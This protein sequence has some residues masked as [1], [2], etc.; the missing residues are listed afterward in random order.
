MKASNRDMSDRY[1]LEKK[2][3]IYD[4]FKAE[5]EQVIKD[6]EMMAGCR[7]QWMLL[8]GEHK[9]HGRGKK[10]LSDMLLGVE[11]ILPS[12]IEDREAEVM[13]EML[14]N[15]LERIGLNI[16]ETHKEYFEAK[17]R[18]KLFGKFID[19]K[20][21][22]AEAEAKEKRLLASLRKHGFVFGIGAKNG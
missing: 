3:E 5:T 4:T 15:D 20:K 12:L 14:I 22:R 13:D 10:Y 8:V 2:Q 18:L 17:E 6:R 16:R 21:E 9:K 11:E 1:F 19:K 7:A